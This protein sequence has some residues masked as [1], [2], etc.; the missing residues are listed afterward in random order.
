MTRCF[1]Q[2]EAYN[3]FRVLCFCY[4]LV[5]SFDS[6]Q[7]SAKRKNQDRLSACLHGGG[8]PQIAEVTCKGSPHFHCKRVQIKMRDYMDRRVSP[9]KRVTSPTWGPLAPCKQAFRK[10]LQRVLPIK[11]HHYAIFDLHSLSL[12]KPGHVQ[13]SPAWP[14]LRTEISHAGSVIARG[15]ITER[16]SSHVADQQTKSSFI[17]SSWYHTSLAKLKLKFKRIKMHC[18][19]KIS[20]LSFLSCISVQRG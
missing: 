11:P 12:P 17:T 10:F 15:K 14:R 16:A 13:I 19:V 8:E 1:L 7:V 5:F 4:S 2:L 20:S 6:G 3:T 9:P 18:Q